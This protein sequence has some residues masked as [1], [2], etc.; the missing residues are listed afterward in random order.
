MRTAARRVVAAAYGGPEVLVEQEVTLPDPGPGQALVAV[1][2]AGVNP[3]DAKLY[4]GPG[5]EA[6][7]P[8]LLGFEASGVVT[9]VAE[10]AADDQG[11][12]AVGDEVIAFRV[13]G[14]YA[15]HLVVDGQA[16]TRKPPALGWAEAAVL[17]LSG[18]TA[19]HALT[20]T[21][22]GD[23]D[24]VLVHG[25]SGGV[26]LYAVQLARLRGA[27]VIAT[28]GERSHDLLRELG[29]EPVGYGEGLLSRVLT[30]SPDGV[31]A[32][33]DLVGT[34]EALDVSLALAPDRS[35]VTSIAAFARGPREGVLLPGGPESEA[36]RDAAR[37]E[38]ARL[39]G[40]GDLRVVLAATYPFAD[41]A[42][43]HRQIASGH[44]T[45]KLALVPDPR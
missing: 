18:A 6:D 29:A 23:G 11:P 31:D 41:A 19:V 40:R 27:R 24:T 4:G 10:G 7:L 38:L 44:T 26:G 17:M 42:S 28:A 2:A 30:L 13:G 34:D 5:D 9:A 8:V 25:G 45:G 32:A 22:V 12:L 35:R 43:A 15:T 39:A 36:I 20:A 33:L 37:P 1:R 16:L 3:I 14:A 21:G